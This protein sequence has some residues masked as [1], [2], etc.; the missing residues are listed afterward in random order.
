M[1]SA[2]G[3]VAKIRSC[4]LTLPEI[5]LLPEMDYLSHGIICISALYNDVC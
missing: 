1:M 3:L 2:H 5:A 4:Y